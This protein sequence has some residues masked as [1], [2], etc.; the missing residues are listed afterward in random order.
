[1]NLPS[2]ISRRGSALVAVL[3]I[4]VI[5]VLLAAGIMARAVSRVEDSS[6]SLRRSGSRAMAW[7]GV[8][9]AMMGLAAQR[10]TLLTGG[11]AT[12]VESKAWEFA[13]PEGPGIWK[14]ALLPL[15]DQGT[16]AISEAALI[17]VNTASEEQLAKVVGLGSTGAAGVMGR[18][19]RG[20][21]LA[22]EQIQV[23]S[24]AAAESNVAET[25]ES[26]SPS[27]GGR[28]GLG[29]AGGHWLTALS[30]DATIAIADGKSDR[31]RASDLAYKDLSNEDK[32][33]QDERLGAGSGAARVWAQRPEQERTLANLVTD[34]LAATIPPEEWGKVLDQVEVNED[35]FVLG[36]IDISRASERVL[37]TL[38]GVTEEVASNL[39]RVRS[40]LDDSGRRD[41]AWPVVSGAVDAKTFAGFVDQITTRSLQYRV[42]VEAG[43]TTRSDATGVASDEFGVAAGTE[44]ALTDRCVFEA[45]IDVAGD[46][47]R[48]AYLRDISLLDSASMVA[49]ALAESDPANA[50]VRDDSLTLEGQEGGSEDLSEGSNGADVT[51]DGVGQDQSG[52]NA[53]LDTQT[54]LRTDRMESSGGL[55]LGGGIDRSSSDLE[56]ESASEADRSDSASTRVAGESDQGS[57]PGG[58]ASRIDPRLGRWNSTS[59]RASQGASPANSS[60]SP[61]SGGDS[62]TSGANDAAENAAGRDAGKSPAKAT[63]PVKKPASRGTNQKGSEGQS[64]K[65]KTASGSATP[66]R[67]EGA[68]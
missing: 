34:L 47:P 7:S 42:R 63:A 17:N 60:T 50:S 4:V 1:M 2:A 10:E 27:V 20:P 61:R 29:D 68:K 12:F 25:S 67:K 55:D 62:G 37:A 64:S 21:I 32:T 43:R 36:R 13:D 30:A 16:L 46:Q 54:G 9:A 6:L 65:G 14:V 52:V 48:I 57:S 56:L 3:V 28:T 45:V 53:A 33:N 49:A 40:T 51:A 35:L 11:D 24:S 38:P 58:P 39:A 23:N 19:A 5:G 18:R 66:T 8:R 31:L 15:D 44:A 22:V 59:L 26:A 41:L